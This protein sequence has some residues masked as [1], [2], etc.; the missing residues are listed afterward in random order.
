V[1]PRHPPCLQRVQ[2]GLS[3]RPPRPRV[4]IEGGMAHAA[5]RAQG[6]AWA[7]WGWLGASITYATYPSHMCCAPPSRPAAP[8]SP[9]LCRHVE[10]TYTH[11]WC[12]SPFDSAEFEA[13][14]LPMNPKYLGAGGG[15]GG[16]VSGCHVREL[17]PNDTILAPLESWHQR[18][19][20]G[21]AMLTKR[22]FPGSANPL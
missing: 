3:P 20:S 12:F 18:A 4:S 2:H 1:L 16:H 8:S 19:F 9:W 22:P 14:R 21:A 15:G 10:H 5:R 6:R 11:T 17:T 7:R 13:F